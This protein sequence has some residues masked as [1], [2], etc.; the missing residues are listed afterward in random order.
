[1]ISQS[2]GGQELKNKKPPNITKV[3]SQTPKKKS[4]YVTPLLLSS[5]NICKI[6][7]DTPI[8]L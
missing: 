3:N 8:A 2:K 6:S 4:F 5:K 1:M 7:G